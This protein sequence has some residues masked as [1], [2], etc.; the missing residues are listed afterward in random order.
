MRTLGSYLGEQSEQ[1]GRRKKVGNPKADNCN[2][3]VSR[4]LALRVNPKH[5]R[6]MTNEKDVQ[7]ARHEVEGSKARENYGAN[8]FPEA[9]KI[10]FDTVVD[11]IPR[12]RHPLR[13]N[14]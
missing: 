13:R 1:L 6:P 7:Q 3:E 10:I 5:R 14:G 8:A 4:C 2:E 12:D 9:L 11:N